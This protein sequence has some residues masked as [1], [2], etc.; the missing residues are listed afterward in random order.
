MKSADYLAVSG[1]PLV[2]GRIRTILRPSSSADGLGLG[3]NVRVRT[4]EGGLRFAFPEGAE[5]GAEFDR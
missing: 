5:N 1:G 4:R 3:T 2:L